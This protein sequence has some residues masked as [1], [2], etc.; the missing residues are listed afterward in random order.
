MPVGTLY[1]FILV[2]DTE[3]SREKSALVLLNCRQ[4]GSF[5]AGKT[6]CVKLKTAS[7]LCVAVSS[8]GVNTTL[9]KPN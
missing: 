9:P 2:N 3:R 4:F 1:F 5:A 7:V 8:D 6:R